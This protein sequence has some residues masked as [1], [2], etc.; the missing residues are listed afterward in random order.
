MYLKSSVI[1]KQL[2]AFYYAFPEDSSFMSQ[3]DGYSQIPLKQAGIGDVFMKQN[4]R[5]FYEAK[6]K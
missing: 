4:W 6:A 5:C 2:F 1:L 3:V